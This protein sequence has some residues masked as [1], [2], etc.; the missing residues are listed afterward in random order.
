MGGLHYLLTPPKSNPSIQSLVSLNS[1]LLSQSS[2]LW[3]MRL[4]H[5]L[6]CIHHIFQ[7]HINNNHSPEPC[8]TC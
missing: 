2:T 1:Q 8:G 5:D 4:G 7:L 3:H 6:S